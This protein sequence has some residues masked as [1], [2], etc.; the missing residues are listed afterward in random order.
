MQ[1][2]EMNGQNSCY[3]YVYG[4]VPLKNNAKTVKFGFAGLGGEPVTIVPYRDVAAVVSSYPVL[5][6]LVNETEAMQ[7]AEILKKMAE[8][9]TVVPMSFGNVF[10]DETTL[11]TVLV[12]TYNHVN[13]CLGLIKGKIELGVKVVKPASNASIGT[14]YRGLSTEILNYLNG[15]CVKAS[16]GDNFSDRLLLNY[17]FLVE[18]ARFSKFSNAI[19]RLEKQHKSLKFIYTGPWPPYSFI[20]IRIR[21]ENVHTG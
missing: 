18:K 8:K 11:K 15:F 16:K 4:I 2:L 7:H 5:K 14:D 9:T 6:P 19:A 21:G 20:N 17:S 10:K 3:L 13:V 1:E 12:K